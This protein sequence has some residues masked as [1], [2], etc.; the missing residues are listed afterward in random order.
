VCLEIC[1]DLDAARLTTDTKGVEDLYQ[2]MQQAC[3]G[4]KH[5]LK[6]LEPDRYVTT[7]S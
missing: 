5:L 7:R 3:D 6:S 4:L 1:A 2:A